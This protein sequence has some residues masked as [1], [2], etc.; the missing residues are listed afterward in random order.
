MEAKLLENVNVAIG[1][2]EKV[3]AVVGRRLSVVRHIRGYNQ[4]EVARKIGV[5]SSYVSRME[6]GELLTLERLIQLSSLY[7]VNWVEVT[8]APAGSVELFGVPVDNVEGKENA[9]A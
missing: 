4:A 1:K 7:G 6:T 8:S 9:A 2:L 5:K 3:K